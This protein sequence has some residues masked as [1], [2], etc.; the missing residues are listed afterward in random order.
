MKLATK[1]IWVEKIEDNR[2]LYEVISVAVNKWIDT[3]PYATL[4]NVV[5][6]DYSNNVALGWVE[7]RAEQGP[8]G[9]YKISGLYGGVGPKSLK[10]Y[11]IIPF[12]FENCTG[13]NFIAVED[14]EKKPRKGKPYIVAIESVVFN[15][16]TYRLATAYYEPGTHSDWIGYNF[17]GCA[18]T[19]IGWRNFPR[20]K[21]ES[22]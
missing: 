10:C 1:T 5:I 18:H 11:M 17:N 6:Q 16:T 19:V 12:P 9:L 21:Q 13:W 4:H 7:S 15:R 22:C 2:C 20:P 14:V 3:P 8:D